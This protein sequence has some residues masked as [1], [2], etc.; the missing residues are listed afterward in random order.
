LLAVLT[1][2][3]LAASLINPHGYKLTLFP[4]FT[5]GS[6]AI[7]QNILEWRSPN[8]HTP[9]FWFFG[10]ALA[11]G[12]LSWL[13]SPRR[14]TGSELLLFGGTAAAGLLS[15][16]HIPLFAVTA[17]PIIAR[18][19][20]MALVDTPVAPLL[21]P[22]APPT[23]RALAAT[24]WL[25]LFLILLGAAIW[26]ADR[27]ATND[28]V[29][30]RHFPVAAV[31]FLEESGLAQG[32]VYNHYD[33][34]GYLVWRGIPVFVDGHTEVYGDEFFLYYLQTFD[35]GEGWRQPLDDFAVDYVLMKRSSPLATLLAVS[36][37]WRELYADDV[38]RI[39]VRAGAGAGER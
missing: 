28:Q 9:Y 21:R 36:T 25:L 18:H 7:Q 6:S 31:D 13:W 34:G 39:F 14:P 33:W 15:A 35:L 27:L 8:F 32:R 4:L 23:S 26:V 3:G 11:V 10:L 37:E 12:A 29:V 22:V 5:L 19:L 38:A 24:N 16:R 30:A 17:V 1:V 20:Y 2:A